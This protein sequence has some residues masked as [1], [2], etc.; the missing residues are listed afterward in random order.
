MGKGKV[1]SHII[2]AN[3][4]DEHIELHFMHILE[5]PMASPGSD[6]RHVTVC[7][8]VRDNPKKIAGWGLAVL[9][10]GE[11]DDPYE[12]Q[13]KALARALEGYPKYVKQQV[14]THFLAYY[15]VSNPSQYKDR[16]TVDESKFLEETSE[17]IHELDLNPAIDMRKL[18]Q[19]E[20]V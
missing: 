15:G 14:W 3:V 10:P 19:V 7:Y 18:I 11:L 6:E 2:P 1:S 20:T 5:T 8:I 13:R 9:H 12:G 16:A 4:Y 17:L